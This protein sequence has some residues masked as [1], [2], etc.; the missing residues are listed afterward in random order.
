[1]AGA[2]AP[3][4]GIGVVYLEARLRNREG[5]AFYLRHGYAEIARVPRMYRGI[6]DG[7]RMAKDLWLP[8]AAASKP[9]GK[10]DRRGPT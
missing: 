7:I 8:V 3:T 9:E 2:T 1:M 4:A 6:E 10:E 5:R